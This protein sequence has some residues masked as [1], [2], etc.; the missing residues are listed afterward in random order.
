MSTIRS[1]TR[2]GSRVSAAE[3]RAL[4]EQWSSLTAAKDFDGLLEHIAPDIVSCGQAGPLQYIAST[5][6]ARCAGAASSR[7]APD[8]DDP[9][10]RTCR[11]PPA[12]AALGM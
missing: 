11:P 8:A 4:H 2:P 5:T 7:M 6:S 1:L 12:Y 3:V 9:L 10:G